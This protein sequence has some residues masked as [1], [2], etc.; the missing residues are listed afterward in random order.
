M[1]SLDEPVDGLVNPEVKLGG[2]LD[3]NVLSFAADPDLLNSINSV[4]TQFIDN[5]MADLKIPELLQ[6]PVKGNSDLDYI[7][8]QVLIDFA[9]RKT[10]TIDNPYFW[11]RNPLTFYFAKNLNLIPDHCFDTLVVN[12]GITDYYTPINSNYHIY[13]RDVKIYEHLIQSKANLNKLMIGA[14]P[15]LDIVKLLVSKG[16]DIKYDSN[17]ALIISATKGYINVVDYLIKQGADVNTC[18]NRPIRLA[19]QY[20]H[21]EI[22][23]M[24]V[25]NGA[26]VSFGDGELLIRAAEY[27]CFKVIEFMLNRNLNRQI[28][29]ALHSAAM[30]NNMYIFKYLVSKGAIVDRIIYMGIALQ[31]DDIELLKYLIETDR[32]IGSEHDDLIVDAVEKGYHRLL[33]ILIDLNDIRIT[34]LITKYLAKYNRLELLKEVHYRGVKIPENSFTDASMRGHLEVVNFLIKNRLV[35][36]GDILDRAFKLAVY[37]KRLPVADRLV[38]IGALIVD[39]SLVSIAINNKDVDMAHY[40]IDLCFNRSIRCDNA[41]LDAGVCGFVDIVKHL[42]KCGANIHQDNDYLFVSSCARGQLDIVKFLVENK[43]NINVDS[44]KGFLD[45]V[46]NNN[47]DVVRYLISERADIHVLK[48]TALK[49]AVRTSKVEIV[50]LLV[51]STVFEYETIRELCKYTH[52]AEINETMLYMIKHKLYSVTNKSY[53]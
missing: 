46:R 49:I 4:R 29:L 31:Y 2:L 21:Y 27:N 22:F 15:D 17:Q 42:F 40:L 25:D 45:A 10:I 28:Q 50:K 8:S 30:H 18:N 48:D 19:T 23:V 41:L 32:T 39:D 43:A 6:N 44:G 1:S 35:P 53:F 34:N 51:E 24:L 26:D 36:N 14:L 33:K 52:C 38:E 20:N 12:L 11:I 7:G 9:Y 16:A 37:H 13:N 5:P 3:I 47:V